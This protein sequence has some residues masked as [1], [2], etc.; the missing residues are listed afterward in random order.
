MDTLDRNATLIGDTIVW[1]CFIRAIMPKRNINRA[2]DDRIEME[3]VVDAYSPEERAMG[4]YCYL[5]ATGFISARME[6][7]LSY[8]SAAAASKSSELLFRSW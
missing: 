2:R 8:C 7:L 6:T 4:W 5:Q 3:V 1:L